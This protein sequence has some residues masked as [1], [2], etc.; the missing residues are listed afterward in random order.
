[1]PSPYDESPAY[2]A[3]SDPNDLAALW[4]HHASTGD[5]EPLLLH[6]RTLVEQ[7]AGRVGADL[8]SYVE[9]ADLVSYGV[10]GLID[11]IEKFDRDRGTKFETYAS[12]RIRGAILDGLRSIDWVPRSVRTRIRAVARAEGALQMTLHRSPTETE[13]AAATGITIAGLRKLSA[14]AAL[15]R[16]VPLDDLRHATAFE[17]TGSSAALSGDARADHPGRALE[18]AEQRRAVAGAIAGLC[19]RD[20][21]VIDLYYYRGLKLTEIGRMLGV[22]EARVSQLHSRARSALKKSLLAMDL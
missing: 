18:A 10:L 1:M 5:T 22:T 4:R 3:T 8:P 2:S 20:R 12:L 7:I 13:V 14:D 15:S 19:D 17:R 6:Y 16:V 11:A 9:R 21:T